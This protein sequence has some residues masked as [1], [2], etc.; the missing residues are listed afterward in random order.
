MKTLL[1]KMTSFL[2]AF[3]M[4]IQVMLPAFTTTS[5]AEE[6]KL[7]TIKSIEEI[8]DDENVN[9]S[10]TKSQLIYDKKHIKKDQDKFSLALTMPDTTSNFRLVKR[11]DLKL[12]DDG[13]FDSNEQASKEYWRVKDMLNSQG[14]DLDLEIINDEEGY[15]LVTKEE[16]E[17]IEENEKESPYGS[18]YTYIDFKVMDDFDFN[19]KG[20]QKLFNEDKLVFNLEF[21]QYESLDPNFNLYEKDKDGNLTIKNEG[22]IFALIRDEYKTLY[23]TKSLKEDFENLNSLIEEKNKKDQEKIQKEEERKEAEKEKSQQDQPIKKESDKNTSISSIKE[24]KK[25]DEKSSSNKEDSSQNK[26]E[27]N[28]ESKTEVTV[29]SNETSNKEKETKTDS[30][31]KEEKDST[32]EETKSQEK[33]EDTNTQENKKETKTQTNKTKENSQAKTREKPEEKKVEKQGLMPKL[34]MLFLGQDEPAKEKVRAAQNNESESNLENK[35]FTIRT[36]FDTSNRLGPIEAGQ[37][38]NIHLDK[39]LTV[40]DLSSLEDII[41]NGNVIAKASYDQDSNTIKYEIVKDIDEDINK[42]LNIDVDYNTEKIPAGESFTVV[43]SIS[44]LGVTN[45]KTLPAEKIDKNGNPAGTIIEEG[46]DDVVQIIGEDDEDYKVNMDIL[47]NPVVDGNELSGINWTLRVD[48]TLDL[49]ELGYKL[50][51]TTVE[52]SGL[53]EIQ[54]VK[55]NGKSVDLTDQLGGKLGIS[56]SKHHALNESAKTLV[57]TFNTPVTNKQASYM[58]DVSTILTA[59]NKVGALRHILNEGYPQDKIEENSPNRTSMN[60]RTTIKGEF[61][62]EDK[63]EWTITDAVS[64]GDT[65]N[66]LPLETR[67]L[68]NQK[69]ATGKRAVYGINTTSGQMEVKNDEETISNVPEKESNPAGEQAVGNIGVYKFDTNLNTPNDPT[70]YSVGGVTISKYK[71]IIVDQHWSLADGYET[72]PAQ[73]LKIIDNNNDNELGKKDLDPE[74]GHQ[75]VI[76]VPNVR[77][78]NIGSD[79][80]ASMI[81]HRVD[82][83]L[84][85]ENIS[86]GDKKYT[87]KENANYYDINSKSHQIVMPW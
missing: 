41:H 35:K 28:K 73:S 16:L 40:K 76:T 71:D 4:V 31:E 50:N 78:W 81:D 30:N 22:D 77:F 64:T 37:Y 48:S 10:I 69:L 18:N 57:Y 13:Y 66:G 59:K 43:N 9:L 72:M 53:G 62:T 11:I 12:Y 3:F 79:G 34:R 39:K 61:K 75:R 63:A 33:K 51:L 74:T 80:K 17:N 60:N 20:N 84:P 56:D 25:Q 19:E 83:V 5:K 67:S 27:E 38:F 47:G 65:N 26:K 82:Q 85:T 6:V 15:R 23:T 32:K 36:R 44:G 52:G 68:E 14:L 45:P 46:R 86:V 24:E 55:M 29:E 21:L 54:N 87:F 7:N 2:M 1:R 42:L 49:K 8:K 58:I 70:D